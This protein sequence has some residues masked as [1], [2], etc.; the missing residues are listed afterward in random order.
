MTTLFDQGTII[1]SELVNDDSGLEVCDA[2][3]GGSR[4]DFKKIQKW[5]PDP[6]D[7]DTCKWIIQIQKLNILFQLIS[8]IL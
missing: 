3:A 4:V 5:V 6:V 7:V 1:E 8:L 2:Y